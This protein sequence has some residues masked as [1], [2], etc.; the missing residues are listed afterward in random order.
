M[1]G[2]RSSLGVSDR[3]SLTTEV[4]HGYDGGTVSDFFQSRLPAL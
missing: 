4:T 1:T 3:E 2:S